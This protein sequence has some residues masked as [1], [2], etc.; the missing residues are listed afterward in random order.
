MPPFQV[1]SSRT[2]TCRR[3]ETRSSTGQKGP[4]ESKVRNRDRKTERKTTRLPAFPSISPSLSSSSQIFLHN[5]TPTTYKGTLCRDR[6]FP[7]LPTHC[8]LIGRPPLT[9][10]SHW[11]RANQSPGYLSAKL[12]AQPKLSKQKSM[13]NVYSPRLLFESVVYRKCNN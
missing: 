5:T 4:L 11:S 2:P 6:H 10:D 12:A 8:P 3:C 13:S 1:F 7:C 9:H